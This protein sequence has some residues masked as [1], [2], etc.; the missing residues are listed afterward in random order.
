MT[1]QQK[2]LEFE[3]ATSPY[4]AKG[5][6][7]AASAK[8]SRG[9][10]HHSEHFV[11]RT[12]VLL[13]MMLMSMLFPS[14]GLAQPITQTSASAVDLSMQAKALLEG[15]AHDSQTNDDDSNNLWDVPRM[16]I[17]KTFQKQGNGIHQHREEL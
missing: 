2:S 4:D 16:Q 9:R 11:P 8:R 14:L 15:M 12:A 13:L 6:P 1:E 17:G 10:V 3:R 5:K 7:K